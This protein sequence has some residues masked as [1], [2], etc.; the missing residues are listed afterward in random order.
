MK[1]D[2]GDFLKGTTILGLVPFVNLLKD[3]ARQTIEILLNT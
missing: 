2:R 3:D 1:F